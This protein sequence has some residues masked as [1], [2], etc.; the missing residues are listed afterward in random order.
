MFTDKYLFS[1]NVAHN[2]KNHVVK[3]PL[4]SE[5]NFFFFQKFLKI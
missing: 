5:F 2:S 1:I 4:S 3:N